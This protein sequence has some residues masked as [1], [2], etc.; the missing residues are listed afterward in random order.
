[1]MIY[2]AIIRSAIDYGCMA[3]GTAA[4][5]VLK[6]LGVVQAKALRICGGAF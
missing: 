3:Y 4:P 1:M 6:R 5:S 2:R